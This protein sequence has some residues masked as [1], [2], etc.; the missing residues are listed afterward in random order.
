MSMSVAPGIHGSRP[1]PQ[2]QQNSTVA[3]RLATAERGHIIN[4]CT[5]CGFT[6]H[7]A[8]SCR[9]AR[10]M[11]KK[12]GLQG[13]LKRVCKK[14]VKKQHFIEC[15]SD[16]GDD[17]LVSPN[18]L[19]AILSQVEEG[20]EKPIAFISRSLNAAEKRYSQIQKETTAIIFVKIER[21]ERGTS[22]VR[23]VVSALAEKSM[24]GRGLSQERDKNTRSAQSPGDIG[25]EQ[26]P[27]SEGLSLDIES[28]VEGGTE[29]LELLVP[30]RT[31][32]EEQ[33]AEVLS[34]DRG[35]KREGAKRLT[36][37][38]A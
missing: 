7:Q 5:A 27:H 35:R 38:S 1:D 17:G 9:L 10:Y 22:R 4:R 36:T 12:C 13:H 24:D 31:L 25:V 14:A 16:G 23:L 33:R 6:G 28:G 3:S 34:R 2:P 26:A 29:A 21:R 32:K 30:I 19:G 11:C 15:S 20:I 8:T 18:G 37:N